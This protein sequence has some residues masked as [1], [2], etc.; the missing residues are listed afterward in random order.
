MTLRAENF[1]FCRVRN[2]ESADRRR[3]DA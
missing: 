2:Q 1:E 3:R